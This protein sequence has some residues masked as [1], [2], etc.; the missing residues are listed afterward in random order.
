[1]KR[2]RKNAKNINIHPITINNK[3]INL[4]NFRFNVKVI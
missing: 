4:Y 2:L 1:M 3:F